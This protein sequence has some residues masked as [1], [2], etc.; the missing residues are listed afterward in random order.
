MTSHAAS[1]QGVGSVQEN[2]ANTDHRWKA[3]LEAGKRVNQL[4]R[5]ATADSVFTDP[6]MYTSTA[7]DSHPQLSNNDDTVN[8]DANDPHCATQ[9]EAEMKEEVKQAENL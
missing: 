5:I 3:D 7:L 4:A 9:A 2:I 8:H 6:H 1:V